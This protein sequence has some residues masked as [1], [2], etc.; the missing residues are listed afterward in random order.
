MGLPSA[1]ILSISPMGELAILLHKPVGVNT[2]ALVP[3]AGGVPREVLD[4]V[5]LAAWGPD[6]R[7]LAVAR[8]VN[9]VTNRI[10]FPIGH[11][12]FDSDNDLRGLSVSPDGN[13]VAFIEDERGRLIVVEKNGQVRTLLTGWQLGVG[14]LAWSGP[15][16]IVFSGGPTWGEEAVRS[17]T[18]DG[19]QTVLVDAAGGGFCNLHDVAADG[20]L[21]VERMVLQGGMVAS[22]AGAPERELSWLDW[23]RARALSSDGRR[24]LFVEA[25]EGGQGAYIRGT[26]G[27]PAVRLGDAREALDLSP[28]GKWALTTTKEDPPRL[29]A[30]PT[31]AGQP[32]RVPTVGITPYSAGFLR[33]GKRILVYA[34]ASRGVRIYIA[35]LDGAVPPRAIT[36]E[37]LP[38]ADWAPAPDD[39]FVALNA[40]DGRAVL[41]PL[42]GG[43][44]RYVPGLAPED[45]PVVW[46]PDGRALLVYQL[47]EAPTHVWRFDLGTGKRTVWRELMP[48][49]PVGVKSIRALVFTPDLRS[50]A[51]SY[52]RIVRSDLYLVKGALRPSR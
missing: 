42:E 6:G 26:D 32:K 38:R 44:P 49:D 48:A 16:R 28:D 33:D 31:G 29:M 9:R 50:Y 15:D 17:V 5:F 52:A 20:R 2:L 40:G 8:F 24:L 23:S 11:G 14:G 41:Y 7:E 27:S 18:L 21:L 36:P 39:R 45:D 4:N 19:V 12:L 1:E 22:V 13:R 3:I 35:D 25:G 43:E 10:E 34:N 37:G 47:G 51:Y 30:L 46:S